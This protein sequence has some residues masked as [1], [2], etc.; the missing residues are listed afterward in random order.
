M[1]KDKYLACLTSLDIESKL[2]WPY[3]CYCG[4]FAGGVRI[5]SSVMKD[6]KIKLVCT[7]GSIFYCDSIKYSWYKNGAQVVMNVVNKNELEI[8][9]PTDDMDAYKC[10]CRSLWC[11][12]YRPG[13][14]KIYKADFGKYTS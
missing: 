14:I 8:T 10:K 7:P 12:Y 11:L 6:G 9:P 13:A 3:S 1:H 2:S 4:Y 5:E